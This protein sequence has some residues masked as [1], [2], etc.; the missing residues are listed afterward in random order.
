MTLNIKAKVSTPKEI[1][2]HL[3]KDKES[4]MLAYIIAP[5]KVYLFA[6]TA[7]QF[8]FYELAID[9][10]F[11]QMLLTLQQFLSDISLSQK[12]P[13][14]AYETFTQTSHALY[15]HLISPAESLLREEQVKRLVLIPDEALSYIP[16][17]VLLRKRAATQPR[18][19][20][21]LPYLIDQYSISYGHSATLL[22]EQ[23]PAQLGTLSYL[24]VAPQYKSPDLAPAQQRAAFS[25]LTYNSEEVK[26][27]RQLWGG[28]I[29]TAEAATETEFKKNA[30]SAT[31]LHLAMHT[32]V[33]DSAPL[34]SQLRFY[35]SDDS[36]E[37]G[38]L[39][40]YELYTLQLNASLAV[41]SACNTGTGKLQQ[42]EGV[43]SLAERI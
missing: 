33:N 30:T 38:M 25:P 24:G 8:E 31:I 18:N 27:G 39:H 11:S 21:R 17:E 42:G 14:T 10:S 29:L 26:L 19:Y 13:Q 5:T 36:T 37:D 7:Q 32:S 34:Y 28:K 3:L 1:Q 22:Y 12:A 43:L 4:A 2:A 35:A 41:L 15:Q 23:G 40:T 6:L 9:E 20:A 16:F